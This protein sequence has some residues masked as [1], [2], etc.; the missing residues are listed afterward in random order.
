MDHNEKD[1]RAS[2]PPRLVQCADGSAHAKQ[3]SSMWLIDFEKV[4]STAISVFVLLFVSWCAEQENALLAAAASTAPTGVPLSLFIVA[5]RNPGA[6][7]QPVL[8]AFTRSLVMGV[9]ST[10][11]FAVAAHLAARQGLRVGG[12]LVVGYA[13]WALCWMALSPSN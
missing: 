10:L 1:D 6:R 12:V 9:L 7:G 5:S 13:A 8:I 11:V 4:T 2:H 3:V